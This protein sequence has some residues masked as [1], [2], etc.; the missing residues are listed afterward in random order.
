MLDKTLTLCHH[1]ERISFG[2]GYKCRYCLKDTRINLSDA[3][4]IIKDVEGGNE[5]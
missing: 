1:C 2:W 5:D 3:Y 4:Y